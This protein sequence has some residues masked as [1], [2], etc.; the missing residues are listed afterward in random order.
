MNLIEEIY[1]DDTIFK[2]YNGV[3][4]DILIEHRKDGHDGF[5]YCFIDNWVKEVKRY[6][7]NNK[8]KSIIENTNYKD[9]EWES[10]NNNY[11]CI[12]QT[13]GIGIDLLYKSIRDK[14]M[15]NHLP[16]S[17]YL[18]ITEFNDKGIVNTGGAWKIE[19]VKSNIS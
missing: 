16:M 12:Y 1:Y 6:N 17:P 7:R 15:Q 8:L 3:D 10:V 11:I 13:D 18:N 9:F 5:I 19:T 14:I 2:F 4:F